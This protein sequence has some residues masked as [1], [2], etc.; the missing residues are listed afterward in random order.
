MLRSLAVERE[1]PR[2]PV[3]E[4]R[5]TPFP[6]APLP[7]P[8]TSLIGRAREVDEVRA[9]LRRPEVRL[10]TLT[11]AGGVGKTRLAIRVAE[12]IDDV[13]PGGVAFVDLAAI[14]DPV[15]VVPTI[16]RALGVGATAGDALSSRL[17]DA[18]RAG[19]VLL[20]LD[21]LEQVV[22]AAPSLVNLL[23]GSPGLTILATS[24][25]VLRISGEREIRVPPLE[26]AAVDLFVARAE[27]TR[28][29]LTEDDLATVAAICA[30]LDCLPLAIELAATRLR[31]LSP[32]A[33]L[34]RLDNRLT[35][36][37][38]GARDLP[39][40]Q[41]TMRDAVAWS[42]DLL[43]GEEQALFRRLAV[44]AGGFT[45]EAVEW[46]GGADDADGAGDAG[47]GGPFHLSD[48][49]TA[50]ILDLV[51]SLLD[52]SLL[53][54]D[55]A[56]TDGPRYGMLETIRAFSWER[57]AVSGEADAVR[58]R[59]A[60]WCL[61]LAERAVP[62]ISGP[63]HAWWL[64][65]LDREQ[66]NLRQ[67]LAFAEERGDSSLGHRLV[68]ALW[69][70][71]E[72]QGFLDEGSAWA[73]RLLCLGPTDE[74]IARAS[75]L[76]GAA[77]VIFRQSNFPRAIELAE[78]SLALA[79]RLGS[80][81]AAAEA[82]TVLGNVAYN[83]GQN[84]EAVARYEESVSLARAAGDDDVLLGALTNLALALSVAEDFPRAAAV[85]DE[86][87][88]LSRA[89]QRRLWEAIALV[90]QGALA[91]R[92][93]DLETA[94]VSFDAALT[95][96]GDGNPLAL[97][98]TLWNAAEVARDR[99]DLAKAAAYLQTSLEK[100]WAWMERR[101]VGECLA[102]LAE[103]AVLTGRHES[104]TRLFGAAEEVRRAIGILDDW[105]Q[106]PRRAAALA[107]AR[108]VLG[109]TTADAALAA[110][111]DLPLGEAVEL[112]ESIA[113]EIRVTP[114]PGRTNDARA[115]CGLTS[116]ELEV[117]RLV[118][119][120]RSDREIGEVLH[121]SHRTVSRHLQSIYTKLDVNSRTA[122]S[123]FAHRHDLA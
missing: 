69:R 83:R 61:D 54:L 8:L 20:I 108:R 43:P 75:A 5:V 4:S 30:R 62:E 106:Q 19:R 122:A 97:A 68:A 63:E 114:G 119:T 41:Q 85:V 120:G 112:A 107:T 121:I 90:R 93:G 98:G 104:A 59:H 50:S 29:G 26:E 56:A 101:G 21:N 15:L 73:E 31:H 49:P 79:L 67:A 95:L 109:E 42:H 40:R 33:L 44:F 102:G 57:L 35:L 88:A 6:T 66:P 32:A 24:R 55:V 111:K 100:R 39:H 22:A 96:L 51:A 80:S 82:V 92:R 70:F 103:L 78:E 27:A 60:R 116:R 110:G 12:G 118:A 13:F 115:T 25:E 76:H 81:G 16:A 71:W 91:R 105:H 2:P 14:R 38:G 23:S 58:H 123:A 3:P 47:G 7:S 99:G 28:P 9:L 84:G 113:G 77:M 17:S 64:R 34:A 65:R 89:R 87:L 53:F 46:I 11:G 52:K 45:L 117:L 37:T 48:A 10:V 74:T 18:L 94:A 1:L 72:A 86:A 36:L